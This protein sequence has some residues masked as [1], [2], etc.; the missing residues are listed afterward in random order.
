MRARQYKYVKLNELVTD[1]AFFPTERDVSFYNHPVLKCSPLPS[2]VNTSV[3]IT[4]QEWKDLFG[5]SGLKGPGEHRARHAR[6]RVEFEEAFYY[7]RSS[8]GIRGVPQPTLQLAWKLG[9]L[10]AKS[11]IKANVPPHTD[12]LA[13]LDE[14]T[15][16][17]QTHMLV[18][19]TRTLQFS[20]VEASSAEGTSQ[21]GTFYFDVLAVERIIDRQFVGVTSASI[22]GRIDWPLLPLLAEMASSFL[23]NGVSLLSDQLGRPAVV[24]RNG[25]YVLVEGARAVYEAEFA[26]V[27]SLYGWEAPKSFAHATG[28]AE[29][30]LSEHRYFSMLKWWPIGRCYKLLRPTAERKPRPDDPA[31]PIVPKAR[32]RIVCERLKTHSQFV[33]REDVV[34]E[35]DLFPPA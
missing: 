10:D 22:T 32:G 4:S 29:G 19:V 21:Q 2:W 14:E 26:R 28:C 7:A 1:E 8:E 17:M 35:D 23:A 6:L 18:V 31:L 34:A 25:E 15:A 33:F 12:R 5:Q 11:K 9:K 20:C 27:S 30:T 24:W 16:K 3:R 13:A